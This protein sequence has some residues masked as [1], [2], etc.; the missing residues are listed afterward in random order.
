MHRFLLIGLLGWLCWTPGFSQLSYLHRPDLLEKVEK[1]LHHTYNF[2][3][4]EAREIQLDLLKASPNHPAPVFLEALIIYWEQ[5]PLLPGNPAAERFVYLLDRCE[6]MAD[7]LVKREETYQ[8]GLF[9]DL[10]GKAFKAMFWADNG[11]SG[12]VVSDL[13][14]VQTY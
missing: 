12:K 1:G 13:S 7:E 8:E 4:E 2:A 3:F 10:F 6:E 14:H 9:F 5:F 11:K